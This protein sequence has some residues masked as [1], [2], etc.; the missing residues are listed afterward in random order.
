MYVDNAV[1]ES[2]LVR[3][4]QHNDFNNNNFTNIYS[5]TLSTQAVNDNQVITKAYV[6]QF[7]QEN[8]QSRRDL[9]INFYDESNDLVKNNQDNDLND[10]K[11]MNLDS[12]TI[13]RDPSSGNEVANKKYIE[14]ELDKITTSRFIQTLQKH[15]KV[16]VGIDTYILTNY[17]KIQLTDT[18]VMK[19]GNTGGY[20]LLYW[21]IVCNDK[22]NSGK[23]SNFVKST[24]TNSPTG[25]SGANSLP[26]IGNTF[27]YIETSSNNKGESVFVSWERT[28][29]LQITNITFYYNRFS[30]LTSDSHKAMG[31][32]RIQLLLEDDTWNTQYIIAKNYQYSDTSTDWTLLNLDFT[33][34]N[35]GIKLIYNEID[36]AH[37]YMCFSNITLTYSVY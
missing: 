14:D 29:F 16:S 10:K 15:P 27:M 37:A 12:I 36:T 23:I 20:L 8:E 11:L 2:S 1:D 35:Y 31:R 7:H 17:N 19:S 24:K 21:K 32:F 26:P 4:N 5:I 3:N 33:I 30:I 13:N 18:A 25:D 22:N 34:A 9:G 6:D 28:D